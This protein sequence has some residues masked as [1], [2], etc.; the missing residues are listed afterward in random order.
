MKRNN[1][2]TNKG[3]LK[4]NIYFYKHSF[5]YLAHTS[6][7]NN[8]VSDIPLSILIIKIYGYIPTKEYDRFFLFLYIK[9][10]F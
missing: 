2:H 7:I 4:K 3:V 8:L 6:I 10:T 5:I 1:L 9:Q